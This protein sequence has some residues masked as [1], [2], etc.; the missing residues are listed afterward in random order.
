MDLSQSHS[1]YAN[2]DSVATFPVHR[3]TAPQVSPDNHGGPLVQG[4]RPDSRSPDMPPVQTA[5]RFLHVLRPENRHAFGDRLA[6]LQPG[7]DF[8]GFHRV[9]ELVTMRV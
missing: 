8:S 9:T 3:V 2:D 7:S 4:I 1:R 5:S 6:W